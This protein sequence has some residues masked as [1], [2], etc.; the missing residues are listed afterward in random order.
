[1]RLIFVIAISI[2]FLSMLPL[3]LQAQDEEAT[4]TPG[5]GSPNA[6]ENQISDDEIGRAH[7]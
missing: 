2:L 3:R 6:V 4:A 5:F 7:V 1:M